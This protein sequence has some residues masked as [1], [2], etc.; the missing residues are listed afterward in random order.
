MNIKQ[1]YA[2]P[3]PTTCT[4]E[5]ECGQYGSDCEPGWKCMPSGLCLWNSEC[6]LS[7]KTCTDVGQC[8]YK[9][10]N[11]DAGTGSCSKG[12]LCKQH[13]TTNYCVSDETT[14]PAANCNKNGCPQGESC[15]TTGCE[16]P[17]N[18]ER[19]RNGSTCSGSP[20]CLSRYCDLDRGQCMCAPAGT[21]VSNVNY[22]CSRQG[23]PNR[24]EG[25]TVSDFVCSAPSTCIRSGEVCPNGTGD[26]CC[27]AS[28]PSYE[29][30]TR[31]IGGRDGG[32]YFCESSTP[33]PIGSECIGR[34]QPCGD[35]AAECC[36]GYACMLSSGVNRCVI[37]PP[38]SAVY[39]GPITDFNSLIKILYNIL[40]PAGLGLGGFFIAKSGYTLMTSEGNPQKVK[41]GQEELTHAI[42]GTIFVLLSIV[43]LRVIINALIGPAGF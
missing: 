33:S 13:G 24:S 8:G 25:S 40:L 21:T 15:T 41:E 4:G 10:G 36:T 1:V 23:V 16:P 30:C 34:G 22:C 20:E 3:A 7:D 39:T 35:S 5:G 31:S 32:T 17:I 11:P 37:P 43:L 12:E 18:N 42:M 14:C 2:A 19:K 26:V 27:N 29:L 9:A 6:A 38:S 28:S